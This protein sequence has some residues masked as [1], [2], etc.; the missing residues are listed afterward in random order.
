MVIIIW[1]RDE[2]YSQP[3]HG[4]RQYYKISPWK[5]RQTRSM[6]IILIL[7]PLVYTIPTTLPHRRMP[8]LRGFLPRVFCD[9]ANV[10]PEAPAYSFMRSSF[11][12]RFRPRNFNDDARKKA[13]AYRLFSG[14]SQWLTR[15]YWLPIMRFWSVERLAGGGWYRP[16]ADAGVWRTAHALWAF[17][18]DEKVRHHAELIARLLA[19]ITQ[20]FIAAFRSA[21]HTTSRF[22]L[23]YWFILWRSDFLL[24]ETS[25]SDF[26]EY[27]WS[28]KGLIHARAIWPAAIYTLRA[29]ELVY[30]MPF[31][32]SV[33][34]AL[35]NDDT[36]FRYTFL[37]STILRCAAQI[38]FN[39]PFLYKISLLGSRHRFQLVAG[40]G[41][42]RHRQ[43][44]RTHSPCCRFISYD[45]ESNE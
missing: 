3:F 33:F 39:M 17:A 42:S 13:A 32:M 34:T 22:G 6:M 5:R 36:Y 9:F 37:M 31:F 43:N 2:V 27:C 45:I 28:F 12:F 11:I 16:T 35:N 1:R 26:I 19:T 24:Q 29:S 20:Q 4:L 7:Q 41:H 8:A 21:Q 25:M 18:D 30:I 40:D 10:M 14:Q 15:E 23:R 44:H 38:T